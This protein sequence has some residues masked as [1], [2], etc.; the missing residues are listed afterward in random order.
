MP[1]QR[2]IMI[3]C[4][5]ALFKHFKKEN[6]F[7]QIEFIIIWL[8]YI[9]D[10]IRNIAILQSLEIETEQA[11]LFWDI[12]WYKT[13]VCMNCELYLSLEYAHKPP[14]PTGF[15]KSKIHQPN[16]ENL[17]FKGSEIGAFLHDFTE[18]CWKSS[19]NA[20]ILHPSTNFLGLG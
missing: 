9:P 10:Q 2:N 20:S 14:W 18:K 4:I 8:Y 3:R 16:P 19:K 1:T 13:F 17:Q 6:I 5:C 12:L 7:I 11:V 15:E